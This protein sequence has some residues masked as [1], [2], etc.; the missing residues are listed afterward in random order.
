MTRTECHWIPTL[1]AAALALLLGACATVAPEADPVY[2]KLSEL[3]GRLLRIER[4]LANQSLLQL[5]Q[6]IELAQ[7]EVRTLRGQ[8]EQI[9]FNLQGTRDQQREL[10]SDVDRRLTQI[11]AGT[12]RTTEARAAQPSGAGLLVPDGDDRANYQAAFDLLKEGKYAEAANGFRQFLAAFPESSLADNAQYW[13]AETHYVTK[14]YE[15]ALRE[16]QTVL[17][18]YPQSRKLPDALLK[19]GYCNYELKHWNEARVA[20]SQVR[21]QFPDTTAARLAGQRLAQM[22]SEGH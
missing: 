15:D 5:A 3:D 1:P 16:F 11:E 14:V 6:Q 4:V 2:Q 19:I 21:Q 13:L 22:D 7:N 20:L 10:Y 8:L 17:N 12:A 9:E 18:R